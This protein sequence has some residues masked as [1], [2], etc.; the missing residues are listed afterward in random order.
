MLKSISMELYFHSQV[1]N[2]L[3]PYK[4]CSDSHLRWTRENTMFFSETVSTRLGWKKCTKYTIYF[5]PEAESVT[6][7]GP[8]DKP[9]F[10]DGGPNFLFNNFHPSPLLCGTALSS[11][12]GYITVVPPC[13]TCAAGACIIRLPS[14]CVLQA[15]AVL[16]DPSLLTRCPWSCP[17]P[18]LRCSALAVASRQLEQKVSEAF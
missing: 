7:E 11:G 17:T 4:Y 10:G 5:T 6:E 9:V 16:A 1:G 15:L 14:L 3:N 18:W 13:P 12:A 2:L 8:G